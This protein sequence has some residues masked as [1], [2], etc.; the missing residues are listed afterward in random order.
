MV[1]CDAHSSAKLALAFVAPLIVSETFIFFDDWRLNDLDL[2]NGGEYLAFHEFRDAHRE[3]SWRD[4]G[5]YNRKS[6]VLLARRELGS[7][8]R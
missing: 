2:A 8:M 7:S 1:D 3:F 4:F 5:A 6:K